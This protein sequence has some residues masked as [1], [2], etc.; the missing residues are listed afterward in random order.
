MRQ[1]PPRTAAPGRR[2]PARRLTTKSVV[3]RDISLSYMLVE[4]KNFVPWT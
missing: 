1:R 3:F 2:T 4:F